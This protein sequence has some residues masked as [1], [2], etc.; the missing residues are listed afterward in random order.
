M[1]AAVHDEA[2]QQDEM[3][4]TV[5]PD[6][7][8]L[9]TA[10][11]PKN[12]FSHLEVTAANAKLGFPAAVA[13]VTGTPADRTQTGTKLADLSS[14]SA[15]LASRWKNGPTASE[16]KAEPVRAGQVRSF[17]I[18]RI[19]PAAKEIQLEPTE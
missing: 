6:N 16:A 14:F 15:M 12:D 4:A 9:L 17:R 11:T 5:T 2:V 13:A 3:Q 10:K 19:D 18:T 7:K 8:L 1:D